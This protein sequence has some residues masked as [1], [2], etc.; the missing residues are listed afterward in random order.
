PENDQFKYA[1]NLAKESNLKSK[2][3]NIT[4]KVQLDEHK[5]DINELTDE[6]KAILN[7]T[8]DEYQSN[9]ALFDRAYEKGTHN[10]TLD[11]GTK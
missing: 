2:S 1:V 8:Y 3:E 9:V 7:G 6:R 4:D 5:R 11:A 10:Q